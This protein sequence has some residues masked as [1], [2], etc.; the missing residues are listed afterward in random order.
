MVILQWKS[1]IKD[2]MISEAAQAEIVRNIQELGGLVFPAQE[3]QY[4]QFNNAPTSHGLKIQVNTALF[5]TTSIIV[6]FPKTSN[7]I[8]CLQN[9]SQTGMQLKL[10]NT[11]IPNEG[12]DTHSVG[13][14]KDQMGTASLDGPL[15]CT[16]DFENSVVLEHNQPDGTRWAN[17]L[18]DDTSY[19]VQFQCERS[20][21]AFV[22]DGINTGGKN[23]PIELNSTPRWTGALDTYFYPTLPQPGQPLQPNINKPFLLEVRDTMFV[24]DLQ[25]LHYMSDKIP[26]NSQADPRMEDPR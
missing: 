17:A 10:N 1:H 16:N 26:R 11:F 2:Y 21:A 4:I 25:G 6:G 14:L 3:C 24:L 8:T 15:N 22:I 9:P 12:F 18:T 5:N 7:E 20:D 19:L 23:V 13:H